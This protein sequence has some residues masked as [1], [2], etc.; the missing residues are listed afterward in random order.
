MRRKSIQEKR[1][2]GNEQ[3]YNSSKKQ[4]N[5]IIISLL[6]YTGPSYNGTLL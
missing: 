3:I 4:Q 1:V 6:S 5:I 2:S